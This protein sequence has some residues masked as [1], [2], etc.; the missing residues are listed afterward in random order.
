VRSGM[1]V[2]KL[3]CLFGQIRYRLD[4][5]SLDWSRSKIC[6][7]TL[8][9]DISAMPALHM[10]LGASTSITRPRSRPGER[11]DVSGTSKNRLPPGTY[12]DS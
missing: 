5:Q 10:H 11:G 9:R 6:T 8:Y 7:S 12:D 3:L 1:A 4:W 2:D